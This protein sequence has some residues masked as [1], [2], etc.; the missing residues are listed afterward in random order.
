MKNYS[1]L[2]S[3]GQARIIQAMSLGQT[4]D[5][6]HIAVGDGG[7]VETT[8]TESATA[9]VNEVHRRGIT[10]LTTDQVNQNWLVIET[11]LPTN[12][13]GWTMREVG[14]FD[15]DGVLF[16]IGSIGP[17]YKAMLAEGSGS[18][19]R[20]KIYV[21]V[22]NAAAVTLVVDPSVTFATRPHVDAVLSSH[23]GSRNHPDATMLAKGFTRYATIAETQAAGGTGPTVADRAIVPQALQTMIATPEQRG[24]VSLSTPEQVRAGD[25]NTAITPADMK[26]AMAAAF[27]DF[28]FLG[29]S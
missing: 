14:V 29:L 9:L 18:E 4:L 10:S 15:S 23:A 12:V 28:F 21:Q 22:S 19:Y 25:A 2:T 7:G 20:F 1:I 27:H 13:G 6:T 8:P 26:K 3:A 11:V 5:L 16:A 17:I 24:M